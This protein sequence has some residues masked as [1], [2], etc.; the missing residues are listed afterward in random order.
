MIPCKSQNY[1]GQ[2]KE[3]QLVARSMDAERREHKKLSVQFELYVCMGLHKWHLMC[4]SEP[5]ELYGG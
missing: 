2:K 1:T 5:V 4:L 3:Q